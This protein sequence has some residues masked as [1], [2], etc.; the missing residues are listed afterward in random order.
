MGRA[1]L[2][3]AGRGLSPGGLSRPS[4]GWSCPEDWLLHERRLCDSRVPPRPTA[5]TSS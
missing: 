1:Q 5:G 2:L 3:T 4:D